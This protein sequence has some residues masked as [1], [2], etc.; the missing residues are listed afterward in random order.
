[1][2]KHLFH[3]EIGGGYAMRNKT[4]IDTS[5]IEP[6]KFET[7][8]FVE[9]T[10]EELESATTD[11]AQDAERDFRAMIQRHAGPLQAAFYRAAMVSGERYTLV[12]LSDFGFPV[13]LRITFREAKLSTYAQYDDA[14]DV[15]FMLQKKR[16]PRRMYLYGKSFL[17]YSGWRTLDKTATYNVQKCEGCT[18]MSSKY[19][20]FD[21]RFMD[22][23]KAMWPDFI[24]A[25][26]HDRVHRRGEETSA[27]I[28]THEQEQA[29]EPRQPYPL[30]P[31][32][33]VLFDA[34]GADGPCVDIEAD[35]FAKLYAVDG[36]QIE[37]PEE[38]LARALK[39]AAIASVSYIDEPDGGTCNFDSPALD[40]S[41]CGMSKADAERVIKGVG[42][43]CHD[44]KP[45]KNHR[46]DDG[47]IIKTPTYLVISGFQSGQGNRHTHMAEAFC[48]SMNMD[49]FETQM[50]YQ[51]D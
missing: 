28:E 23:I 1:M 39:R 30:L 22:D 27:E 45:F 49:G 36:E 35:E 26:D 19:G 3:E 11:N 48:Q 7:M 16:N 33:N 21:E 14:V 34:Q 4:I 9:A 51:M 13:D 5:E 8:T 38:R 40:F 2:I 44:W 15:T 37:D 46:G 12:F 17:V 10:G 32:L 24:V 41:A 42:L 31:G 18:V 25:Y 43:F 29:S 47:K 20:S 50:Y 6:G